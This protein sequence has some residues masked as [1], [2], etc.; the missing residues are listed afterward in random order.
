MLPD[1]CFMSWS[2]DFLKYKSRF[3]C[4]MFELCT[5]I[6]LIVILSFLFPEIS[7]PVYKGEMP[8]CTGAAQP[9]KPL[10]ISFTSISFWPGLRSSDARPFSSQIRSVVVRYAL[11]TSQ[12]V[13]EGW[14]T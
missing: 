9:P 3:S 12:S 13:S 10:P 8:L 5:Y 7:V 1:G 4:G 11:A 14:A 2:I 6:P